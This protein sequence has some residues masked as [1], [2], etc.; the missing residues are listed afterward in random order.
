MVA[1][2]ETGVMRISH[3]KILVSRVQK[4]LFGALTTRRSRPELIWTEA[5]HI[6][7][8]G[9]GF[10]YTQHYNAPNLSRCVWWGWQRRA[11]GARE[12]CGF[13]HEERCV[14]AGGGAFKRPVH[15]PKRMSPPSSIT[16]HSQGVS[17]R[18][19]PTKLPAVQRFTN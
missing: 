4:D 15:S 12:G 1:A 6:L 17:P 9:M 5:V 13:G 7:Q 3:V 19:Q 2:S 18:Q 11:G 10:G 16:K 14:W 8:K